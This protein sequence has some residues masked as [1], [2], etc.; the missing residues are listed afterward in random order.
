LSPFATVNRSAKL[1]L[2]IPII[3][4]LALSACS[5]APTSPE[6]E[7]SDTDEALVSPEDVMP[8]GD[9]V[10][11]GTQI[12]D[13]HGY[14][15]PMTINPNAAALG[16]NFDIILDSAYSSGYTDKDILEAQEFVATFIAE[17][18]YDSTALDAPLDSG[19][20]A[21]AAKTGINYVLPDYR[22]ILSSLGELPEGADRPVVINSNI[23]N[24]N[25]IFMRDGDSRVSNATIQFT[26]IEG[27]ADPTLVRFLAISATGHAT[28]KVTDEEA[29]NYIK[30]VHPELTVEELAAK[31]HPALLD[32]EGINPWEVD[33][34]MTYVVTK[35]SEDKNVLVGYNNTITSHSENWG[36]Q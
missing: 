11:S 20:N 6:N 31:T 30:R 14:Y 17:Q 3:S 10:P 4:V 32:G 2:L 5:F 18:T 8:A 34:D 16:M 23:N 24:N 1:L 22:N 15:T 19:Y 25:P 7:P 27:Q 29:L 26:K 9:L 21:W 12:Q 28:Y 13:E 35:N 36:I 33:Y